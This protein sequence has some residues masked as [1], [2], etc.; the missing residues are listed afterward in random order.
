MMCASS[1][2]GIDRISNAF[3][4]AGKRN[5][6]ALI[7]YVCGGYETVEDT[8][9]ILFAK[10][11][12]GVDIIE[13][14]IPYMFP[15]ADGPT[16]K[17]SHRVAINNGTKGVI[18]CLQIVKSARS[19]GLTTPI[20]LMGYYASFEENFGTDIDQ[21][22]MAT[23]E[24]GVDGFLIVG[25]SEGEQELHFNETCCNYGITNIPLALPGASDERLS[26]LAAMAST[27]I[28]V[29]SSKGK[30]GARES[31]SIDL[32]ERIGI[33]RSKTALPLA[34][35]FGISSCDMVKAVGSLADVAPCIC[36]TVMS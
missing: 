31:L 17:N 21:L 30:T 28:Y 9:A 6:T 15:W 33:V 13:L 19:L 32:S 3:K 7:T 27:F 12:A 24:S 20:I 8:I 5:E 29:V 11:K 26:S 25:M 35:G 1:K 36:H 23:R 10:Q 14:G 34:V 4:S 16:I 18:D 22:C 2:S